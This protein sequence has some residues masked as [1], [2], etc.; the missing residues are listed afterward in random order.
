[1]AVATAACL[2]C[3]ASAARAADRRSEGRTRHGGE[4]SSSWHSSA[5]CFWA[6][7]DANTRAAL[8]SSDAP[9]GLPERSSRVGEAET[10][11]T[12]ATSATCQEGRRQVVH[13]QD[14]A[15]LHT[16][17]R[18]S[19]GGRRRD[20]VKARATAKALNGGRATVFGR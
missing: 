3:V 4:S 1:M 2:V 9:I 18:Q 6:R 19:L 8:K 10:P 13:R 15:A 17:R 14:R 12:K 20:Q 5:M 11:H 16:E 7:G